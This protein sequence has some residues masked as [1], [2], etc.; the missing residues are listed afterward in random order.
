M[1][2]APERLPAA[3]GEDALETAML[4]I[5]IAIAAELHHLDGQAAQRMNFAA[6]KAYNRLLA[7]DRARA[8]DIVYRFGRALTDR[9]LFPDEQRDAPEAV[10]PTR[11]DAGR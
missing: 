10:G 7:A 2:R 8:A 1:T 5:A 6:G 4:E 11:P 9:S 3:D